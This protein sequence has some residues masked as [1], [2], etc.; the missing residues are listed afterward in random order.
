MWEVGGLQAGLPHTRI[1]LLENKPGFL[2]RFS[3]VEA[4]MGIFFSSR[5]LPAL[6]IP[7]VRESCADFKH[8]MR[9]TSY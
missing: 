3:G 9:L 7:H 2:G 8:V 5:V 6:V 4:G 1:T